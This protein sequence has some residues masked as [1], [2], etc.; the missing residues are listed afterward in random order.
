MAIALRVD[1]LSVNYDKTASLWDLTF[2]LPQGKL[3]GVVGPNGAGK[4]TLLKAVLG[5]VE[6]VA[7]HIELFG[8][9]VRECTQRI[10]YV[11]Q[12]CSVDWDFPIR[13]FDVVLMGCYGRLGLCKRPRPADRQAAWQ[14]LQ[15]VGMEAHAS[16]QIKQLSGGQQQRIFLARALLQ[17]AD[18]YLLDEPFAGVDMA[19]E[20]EILVLL[21]ELKAQGKTLL[22]VH[23]DLNSVQRYFDWLVILNT[24]LVAAGPVQEV[25]HAQN[26]IRAYGGKSSVLLDEAA[27]LSLHKTQGM[28]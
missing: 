25:F 14:A 28:M 15:K 10:C 2:S 3:I 5:M 19:T 26:L 4:S 11:P 21:E 27:T 23:H 12:R 16:K 9:P 17:E 20:R 8:Q 24:S 6:P 7:G 18:L 22:V 13:V 1:Q